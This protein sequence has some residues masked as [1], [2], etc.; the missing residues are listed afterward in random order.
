MPVH[1]LITRL[2]PYVAIRCQVYDMMPE[3]A[4]MGA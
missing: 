1:P 2:V 4:E 3:S